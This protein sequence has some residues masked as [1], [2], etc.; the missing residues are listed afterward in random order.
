[1]T[2]RTLQSRRIQILYHFKTTLPCSVGHDP[3]LHIHMLL[4]F[5]KQ[6]VTTRCD[7]VHKDF[8]YCIRYCEA[9]QVKRGSVGISKIR[10]IEFMIITFLPPKISAV[11]YTMSFENFL[12]EL[13]HFRSLPSEFP[14]TP[15]R[16]FPTS[17]PRNLYSFPTFLLHTC[18]IHP[19]TA[20]HLL[21]GS[22]VANEM[23]LP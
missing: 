17:F 21:H 19:S 4:C 13:S 9:L 5:L 23:S 20:A 12:N 16:P 10:T 7:L 15:L 22:N 11:R 14:E 8:S 2:W 18:K 1:M 6:C 3:S